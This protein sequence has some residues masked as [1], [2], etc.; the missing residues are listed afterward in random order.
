[1]REIELRTR[2]RETDIARIEAE[3]RATQLQ[4]WVD[5]DK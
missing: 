1:M 2:L 3:A 4:N 5:R